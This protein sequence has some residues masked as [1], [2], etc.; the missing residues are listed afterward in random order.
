MFSQFNESMIFEDGIV[1]FKS[2][3]LLVIFQN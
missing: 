3:I 1:Y 2:E